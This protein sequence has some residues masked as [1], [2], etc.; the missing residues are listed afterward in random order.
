MKVKKFAAIAVLLLVLFAGSA[1]AFQPEDALT[2]R[3]E[4]SV[5]AV[6]KL[7]DTS[8]FLQWLFSK[9]NV[10]IFA[11]LFLN[12]KSKM[13]ILAVTEFV[14]AIIP[15]IPI[16]SAAVLSGMTKNDTKQKTQFV[17]AA[18]TF[19]PE[20]RTSVLRIEAGLADASDVAKMLI[21][22]S[23]A[24]KFAETMINIKKEKDNIY[25]VN[26]D[27]FMTAVD[28]TVLLGSS[29]TEIR[30]AVKSINDKD[31][32]LLSKKAR[33]FTAEDFALV[34]ID[35]DT[36]TAFDES[37]KSG[38]LDP[39]KYFAKP[40][41][42]E[43]AFTRL[44]DKFL[45]SIGFNFKDVLTKKYADKLAAQAAQWEDVK[46]GHIDLDIGGSASPLAAIGTY[47]NFET[48]D[49]FDECKKFLEAVLRNLRVRF[50]VSNDETKAL[51]AGPFS[52][53]VNDT[54]TY[55]GFK[56][57][58]VYVS[59]QGKT[60]AAA[61][62]Y[63]K[64]TQ[65]QHFSKVKDGILQ[66]DSSISP[67]SCLVADKGER[68]GVYFAELASLEQ[69]PVLKP[70]L[71][72]LM[73]KES[74]ASSWIDFEGI[75]SWIL[76]ENNGV[77]LMLGPIMTFGGYGKYYTAL[78]NV[79]TAEFSVPSMSLWGKAPETMHIEFALKEINPENGLF[80]RIMKAYQEL[81]APAESKKAP[82]DDNGKEKSE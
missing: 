52:L 37:L 59:Q 61:K 54:V 66:L 28:G 1:C 35:Y 55:E 72:E 80:M 46:G 68:L 14:N 24:A 26:N 19:S 78:Q 42:G 49:E 73:E 48:L 81:N 76:D 63:E 60:G 51:L 69:K 70:A 21:G 18:L 22:D 79:L 7:Q 62:V 67:V 23:T 17:Q 38:D 58:A 9:E 75:Q 6:L 41:E 2:S 4:D 5:Y 39:R 29:V 82:E 15:M 11:P 47:I 16:R 12:G 40:L 77:M 56:I 32:R 50:K 3:P 31:T 10:E 8:K 34:H 30:K 27:I 36:I 44:K 53:V 57:P 64:F 71:A 43:F 65:S 13:E 25:R 33:K 74:T 20:V 45:M